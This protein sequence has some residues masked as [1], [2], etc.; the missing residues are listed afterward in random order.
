[1]VRIVR[2]GATLAA[3]T[4]LTAC[5]SSAGS[6]APTW[7]PAPSFNGVN[8]VPGNPQ[9]IQPVQPRQPGRSPGSTTPSQSAPNDP[10]QDPN[11]VASKLAAPTGVVIMPDNT[12]LVGE[13]TTGR[14]V[15]VH[16]QPGQPVRTVR[17]L[18]GLSTTGGGGLL[19]LAIS[20]HYSQDYLIFAYLTTPAD[21]RVVTFT[22]DGPVTAVL[23][24]IPRGSSDN[25]GRI[26]FAPDGSLL[27]GTG[28]AG[29]PALAADPS[30]LAGKVLR[31]TDIGT[32]AEDNPMQG[33]RIWT[34]GHR[35]VNGLCI[36]PTIGTTFEIET[37]P[38]A[39]PVNVLVPSAGYGWPTPAA[40]Y[41]S[42]QLL[43]PQT[44]RSPGGCA[45]LDARIYITSRDGEELLSA[46]VTSDAQVGTLKP[47][48][49][50]KYGRLL[51]VVAAPDGALW[52]TTSN[53]D[54]KGDPV[55]ADERVLR[56]IPGGSDSDKT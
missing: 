48:L 54:G 39:D 5:G 11:V 9:P 33:S 55:T 23:T 27:V 52:L 24:G 12:A 3:L 31:V 22:L 36:D 40:R 4:V 42:P 29:H 43:L 8:I 21:N 20:P 28:D 19:D 25:A 56:I 26:V 13:R 47:A 37:R 34:S 44:G 50:G 6:D 14:I 17:T 30:S 32:P 38:K 15:R 16:P 49:R 1:M 45:V 41:T 53:R 46:T 35:V 51:T 2:V 18:T 7:K 10:H